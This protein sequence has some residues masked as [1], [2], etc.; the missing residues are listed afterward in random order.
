M[1]I[2]IDVGVFG[3]LVVPLVTIGNSSPLGRPFN[4]WTIMSNLA[5][6]SACSQ[7]TSLSHQNAR[8][9]TLIQIIYHLVRNTLEA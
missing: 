7:V 3:H 1:Y 4:Y 6:K 2:R 8:I 5:H 9:Q